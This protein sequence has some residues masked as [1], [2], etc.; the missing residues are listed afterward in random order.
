MRRDEEH[1]IAEA[2]SG[3]TRAVIALG[4][5]GAATDMGAMEAH[6]ATVLKLADALDSCA[7]ALH[8][9]ASAVIQIASV[10]ERRL[11]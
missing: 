9:I 1:E 2:L 6:G 10:Y 4:N 7:G 3:L 8:D 11:P 5:N